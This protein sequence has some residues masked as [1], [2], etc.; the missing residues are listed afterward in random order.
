MSKKRMAS[1]LG[2]AAVVPTLLFTASGSA[3]AAG[4]NVTWTDMATS[5]CLEAHP[6]GSGGFDVLTEVPQ[7]LQWGCT[8]NWGSKTWVDSQSNL[9]NPDGAWAEHPGDNT[10]YCLTS[11][12]AGSNGLGS[13]YTE[14][15]SSP[16]NYYEQWYEKWDGSR[17]TL[18]N[19]ET[20]L[21]LDSNSND[22]QGNGFGSV[23][24][25]SCN[26]GNYQRWY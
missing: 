18:V 6:N 1:I 4:G 26:G 25:H 22:G 5:G 21:C 13:V 8:Q 20:G 9:Q 2:V 15:C 14:P 7:T 16:A 17:F 23:Y 19:R 12:W 11:Y 24:T 10:G 3:S